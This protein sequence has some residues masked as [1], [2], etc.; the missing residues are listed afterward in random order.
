MKIYSHRGNLDG[1]NRQWENHPS[2][3]NKAISAQFNVE[4]DFWYVEGECWLGHD[5]PEHKVSWDFLAQI[6]YQVILHAKNVEALGFLSNKDAH[7]FWHDTD[8]YTL[9][10]WGWVWMHPLAHSTGKGYTN[11]TILALP[12]NSA[13]DFDQDFYTNIGGVCTDYPERWREKRL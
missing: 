3:I 10:S 12:E 11:M 2:Q 8:D 9:T 6:K 13:S 7:Y 4:I 5:F 1:S